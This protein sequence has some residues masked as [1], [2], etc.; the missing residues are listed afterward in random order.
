MASIRERTSSTG[1]RTWQVLFRHGTRQPSKTFATPKAARAFKVLIDEYGPDRALKMLEDHEETGGITVAELAEKF[2]TWKATTNVT[3][4]TLADYRRDIDNWVIPWLG[5]R[6]AESIDEADVQKWVD[7]MRER[8]A[9]KSVADRH[10][11]LHSMYQFG[12]AKTRN[13]VTHNPCLETELPTKTK[14]PPKG[15]T[16]TE[17]QAIRRAAETR[18]PDAGD[19][20][21]FLGSLGWRWSE[22]AALA[23]KDVY[24]DGDHVWV[25]VTRVFRIVDNRQVL[26]EGAAKSYAG[27]RRSRVPSEARTMLRR[28][29]IGK[30]PSDYVFTNSRGRHWNQNTFLRDTW[31]GLLTAA[32]VGDD[33]RKPTPHWLRHM[34]V[35]NMARAGIPMH[36][37]QRIIGHEDVRTTNSTY[38]G[39]VSTL[40]AAAIPALDAVLAGLEPQVIAGTVLASRADTV[41]TPG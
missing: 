28:R 26:V 40:S 12:K 23:V 21:L 39:M 31:P 34:A 1:E 5:H 22:A 38:G 8:L 17:W 11:L 2:L 27:F 3:A 29:I 35:A 33:L 30:R 10:M 18:N 16:T 7:H 20:I 32:G 37:I 15:T 13:L 25:D 19:L 9:P 14:T 36:E 6:T 4:R 24:D 41:S